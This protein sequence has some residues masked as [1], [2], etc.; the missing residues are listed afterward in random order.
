LA[1]ADGTGTARYALTGGAPGFL[2][3]TTHHFQ[4]LYRDG[5]GPL[6]GMT[7]GLSITFLP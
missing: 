2:A 3:G 1:Q 6:P 7:D 5:N 4:F